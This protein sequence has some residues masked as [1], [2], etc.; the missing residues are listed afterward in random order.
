MQLLQD[1]GTNKCRLM[2]S[3]Q[4]DKESLPKGVLGVMEGICSDYTQATRNENFMGK[5]T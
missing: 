2:E 5:S 3:V 1:I 4:I